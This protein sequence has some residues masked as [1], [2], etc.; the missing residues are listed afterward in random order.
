MQGR[1]GKIMFV[2]FVAAFAAAV[3]GC[4]VNWDESDDAQDAQY[5]GICVD[6]NDMR[7]DDNRCGDYDDEGFLSS[8]DGM[9]YVWMPM[10]YNGGNYQVPGVG[11]YAYQF[12]GR[13]K[14]LTKVPKGTPIAKGVPAKPSG[15]M[16]SIQRG[17][18]GIKSG[19]TGGIGGKAIAGKGGS[20]GS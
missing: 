8:N 12:V 13:D 17:G 2:P 10:S 15:T 5:A 11:S 1:M 3:A 16:S 14:A 19:T 6:K 18:F 4:D 9:H 20:A 7:V